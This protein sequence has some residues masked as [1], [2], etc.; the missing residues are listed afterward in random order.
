VT[1]IEE[2]NV[3][4][5]APR[6]IGLVESDARDKTRKVVIHYSVR[7]PR[8]GK[9]IRRRSVLHV[10]DEG[11][12]SHVGDTVEVAECRPLSKTK[13]WVLTRIVKKAGSRGPLQGGESP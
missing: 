11:N 7:H 3:S 13:N 6:R 10:H 9:Y 1:H 5:R 12:V 2:I 4:D 8:Y